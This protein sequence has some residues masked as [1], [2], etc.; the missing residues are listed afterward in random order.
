MMQFIQRILASIARGNDGCKIASTIIFFGHDAARAGAQIVLLDL[1]KW[2]KINTAIRF[3]VVLGHGGVLLGEYKEVSD[4]YVIESSHDARNGIKE[5]C[6]DNVGVVY[7]NTVVAGKY[8]EY[9]K[10][11][12]VP[13]I[14]CVHELEQ[15]IIKFAGKEAMRELVLNM[16]CYIVVSGPVKQNLMKNHGIKEENIAVIPEFIGERKVRN[17]DPSSELRKKLCL[18]EDDFLVF[19][20]GT[21]DWRKGPD[22]FVE[23]AELLSK[24]HVKNFHFFWLGS[25]LKNEYADIESVAREK[26]LEYRVTFLGEKQNPSEYFAAGDLFLLPSREDPFPL[27]CLEAARCG[28]PIICFEGAGGMP[29]FVTDDVGFVVPYGDAASMASKALFLMQHKG[30]A[31]AM[32]LAGREKVERHYAP[33]VVCPQIIKL[34]R[35]V[36]EKKASQAQCAPIPPLVSI[37]MANYN[38]EKYL[39]EAIDSVKAQNYTN[40]ELIV[41]DDGS[42]DNSEKVISGYLNDERVKL[43]THPGHV[44]RGLSATLASAINEVKGEYVAFLEYDDKWSY[45]ML[46][47]KISAF[48][49]FPEAV[50]VFNDIEAFGDSENVPDKQGYV[51][52]CVRKFRNYPQPFNAIELFVKENAIPTFSSVMVRTGALSGVEFCPRDFDAWTDWW[53]WS[54]VA[55]RGEFCL[56]DKKMT[57]WRIH[58][59]SYNQRFTNGADLNVLTNAYRESLKEMLLRCSV[60][61]ETK[62]I[63]ESV[64][65]D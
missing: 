43:R 45:S 9:F 8:L 11:L 48:K 15:S 47:E 30:R 57:H 41:F 35:S 58:K 18:P 34:I 52:N 29:E 19:G 20:C 22:I 31:R 65:K 33:N 2:I 36:V 24:M 12:N 37:I 3:K 61:E 55:R 46:S 1:L 49:K 14:C 60:L 26:E 56:A 4:V 27:V 39:Q 62:S 5:F 10:Y 54:Q 13:K 6:G 59:N 63:I 25:I 42:I 32:G 23:T 38:G 21:V 53:I 44:N 16:D 40:W 28:L 7:F 51:E 17:S 64:H 50:L